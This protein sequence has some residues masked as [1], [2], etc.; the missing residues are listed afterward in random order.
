MPDIQGNVE[1]LPYNP[2]GVVA[3]TTPPSTSW[4][5]LTG[6]V[7]VFVLIL[8]VAFWVMRKVNS[9]SRANVN[10]TWAKVLDRQMLSGQQSLYLVEVA[11]KLQIL[12]VTE[13]NIV[14]LTDIDDSNLAIDI[15]EDIE[16]NKVESV[17]FLNSLFNKKKATKQFAVQL[18]GF[19]AEQDM[20]APDYE[21]D[22]D[23][24]LKEIKQ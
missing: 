3:N 10:S 7:L 6:T 19:V 18:E 1:M 13:H 16:N 17:G 14:K 5:S 20:L 21:D 23:D 2:T 11:G 12:A 22:S 9:S 8:I 15:L 24:S 4:L